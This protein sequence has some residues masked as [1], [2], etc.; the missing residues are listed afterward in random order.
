MGS[1]AESTRAQEREGEREQGGTGHNSAII[2]SALK[3]M[4]LGQPASQPH[5]SVPSI[6]VPPVQNCGTKHRKAGSNKAFYKLCDLGVP[7]FPSAQVSPSKLWQEW[8]RR[9]WKSPSISACL[10]ISATL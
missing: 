1:S 6:S 9:L 4:L 3:D 10:P 8:T 2:D 7:F 5:S